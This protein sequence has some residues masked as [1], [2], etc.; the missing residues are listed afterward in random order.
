MGSESLTLLIS[1]S[2]ANLSSTAFRRASLLT[3]VGSSWNILKV[4]NA[5]GD[6]KSNSTFL[7]AAKAS[8]LVG[9]TSSTGTIQSASVANKVDKSDD[10]TNNS[11][12]VRNL[13]GFTR[14]DSVVAS[15][16]VLTTAT[17]V[18]TTNEI[19]PRLHRV[20][21]PKSRGFLLATEYQQQL[22]GGFKGFYHLSKIASALNLSI[23]EPFVF[24]TSLIGVP[25]LSENA[26]VQS[27]KLSHFYDLYGLR[28]AFHQCSNIKL[29]TFEAFFKKSMR[30][31]MFVDFLTSL[32]AY[33]D[34]FPKN[35][36]KKIIDVPLYT[37]SI[38]VSLGQLNSWA[39][40]LFQEHRKKRRRGRKM[41]YSFKKSRAVLID[42]QPFHP[43]SWELVRT[44]LESL[45][46]DEMEKHDTV[47]IVL[48]SWRDIKPPDMI[49]SFLYS[50][51]DFSWDYCR[52]MVLIPHSKT[53]MATAE[54]FINRTMKSRPVIGVHIR[55]ER[56]LIDYQGDV[57]HFLDCFE[58]LKDLLSNGKV[59]SVPRENVHVFHDLGAYGSVT[60]SNFCKA[61]YDKVLSE[62]YRSGY[63]VVYFEPADQ[64]FVPMR[65]TLA[66][67][68]DCEYLT[69]VDVLVTVGRG[70]Y[71]Q[72]IVERF[73]DQSGGKKDN[74][75]RICHNEHPVPACY[76]NC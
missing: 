60:C 34:F 55:A 25:S 61:G 48:P 27:L 56:L 12:S 69:R 58:T 49:S 67:F 28:D 17:S 64:G 6:L 39:A 3:R 33:N 14:E 41:R 70:E 72:N 66:A 43:V 46:S 1:N 50:M 30:H 13:L 9:F 29:E 71:Q 59:P 73:L 37:N 18:A 74:L 47:T 52:D 51:P 40:H 32:D 7:A 76:P 35:T 2:T 63:K 19:Q 44:S 65:R 20:T 57:T 24:G 31:V 68:V 38:L 62:I 15:K 36:S 23:V 16:T 10:G 26:R 53:V 22:L 11:R 4:R 45:I 54:K 5:E 8:E 42:A 75:H 21:H